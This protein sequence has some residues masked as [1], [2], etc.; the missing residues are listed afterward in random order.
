MKPHYLHPLFS[1]KHIAVVGASDTSGSI[2]QIL[3]AN[4][5]TGGFQGKITPINIRHDMVG[6]LKAYPKLRDVPE[7]IDVAVIL[8]KIS[9]LESVFRDC[10]QSGIRFAVLLKTK[11]Q[12]TA[13]DSRLWEKARRTA[14]ELGLRLLG[15]SF[16]GMMRPFAGLNAGIHDG[17]VRAG[18]VALISQS[19]ALCSAMLDWAD[20][21]QI[22]FS[23]VL[24]LGEYTWDIDFG[25]ILDY[26]VHDR[27]TEAILLH[28]HDAGSGRR[29]MSALRAAARSKPV[30]VLKSGQHTG[31]LKGHTWASRRLDASRV[32]DSA[33]ARA[34]VLQVKTVSE[35]FTAV[36]VLAAHYR[37]NGE[38]LAVVV[39]GSGLGLM[40]SDSAAEVGVPLA[41]LTDATR[42]ALAHALPENSTI[43]NPVDILGDAGAMRFATAV[44][45]CLDDEQTDAVLVLFSPQNGTDHLN[46][47]KMMIQLQ[48]QTSKPIL[49]S[50]L[51]GA[52]VQSS[53]D[54]FAQARVLHFNSPEQAIAVFRK[55]ADY[56][57][58]QTLLLQTPPPIN[59]T[60][61]RPDLQAAHRLLDWVAKSGSHIVP[62][63]ISKQLLGLFGI[64]TNPTQL[65]LNE[66]MAADIAQT[67]GYPVVLKIDSPDLFYKSD[68]DGVQLNIANRDELIAAYRQIIANAQ[69][70]EPPI[71]INGITVQPMFRGKHGREVTVSVARDAV[72][73]PVITMGAGGNAADIQG[74]IAVALPPLNEALI[75]DMFERAEVGKTFGHYR[76]MPPIDRAA[77]QHLLLRVSEMVCELPEVAEIEID[78]V[79]VSP[80][81]IM[82]LDAR[83]VL[84]T[85]T[86]SRERYGHM[87]IMPYP[88]FLETSAVLKDQTSVFV[89]PLRPEDADMVQEFVRNMSDESRYNRFMSTIKQLSQNVLVRFTQLDYDREMAL[90]M[91]HRPHEGA[92]E[93]M[94]SIARYTT[95][96]DADTCEFG[97]SVS[98]NWQGQG[99][100][101]IMMNLLFDAARHQGLA[102]MRG[103]ILSANTG[104]QKLTRKLGFTVRK[105]PD[106][107]SICIVERHLRDAPTTATER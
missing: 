75:H 10:A 70:A 61:L 102:T 79:I 56:S 87:A 55:L 99:I 89:R 3:F 81:G 2:G 59:D 4:L 95:D 39:N 57:R 107:S 103:E 78:P 85:D 92:A 72:F 64:H 31:N 48:K 9:A 76:N 104:M 106:D 17:T 5:L 91:V 53:R 63:H 69:K 52:K 30:V 45:L 83:I 34:G 96:P 62:E 22:G 68:I 33:L 19:S 88:H 23:T 60:H 93:E 54:L 50:W 1:P 98:D 7:Q 28:I 43:A 26:L 12:I 15:P 18:N 16:L 74:K 97:I 67:M 44:R 35:M 94:L 90:V 29:F 77:L 66:Q 21:R 86:L 38:R 42:N 51:G 13:E 47:A 41:Q 40:A 25:E 82:V 37:S 105:D 84:E 80:E 11:S 20:S 46:T 36:R 32:F 8:T 71:R 58:N 49:L 6:G 100:G 24:S 101:V 65:A 14:A 27:A 73:G